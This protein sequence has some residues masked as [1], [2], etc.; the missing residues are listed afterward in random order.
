[1]PKQDKSQVKQFLVVCSH[2]CA[3]GGKK[4]RLE[5]GLPASQNPLLLPPHPHPTAPPPPPPVQL[6]VI[7]C[8]LESVKIASFSFC[9]HNIHFPFKCVIWFGNYIYLQE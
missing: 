3:E 6:G 9:M 7:F 4:P 2:T 8:C 5:A 1:M